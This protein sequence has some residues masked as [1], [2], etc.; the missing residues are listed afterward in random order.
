MNKIFFTIETIS[1]PI[2]FSKP[3]I[4]KVDEEII[5]VIVIIAQNFLMFVLKGESSFVKRLRKII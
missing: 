4:A 2:V 3:K 1:F 5:K